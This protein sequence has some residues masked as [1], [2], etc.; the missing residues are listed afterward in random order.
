MQNR[1][2]AK[3][4]AAALSEL[5]GRCEL[6]GNVAHPSPALGLSCCSSSLTLFGAHTLQGS[7]KS[8]LKRAP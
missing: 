1:T 2:L 4:K 3:E 7:S 8:Q 6:D 5:P